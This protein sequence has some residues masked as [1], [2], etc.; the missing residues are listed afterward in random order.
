MKAA[1]RGLGAL[2]ALVVLVLLA[3]LAASV[4]RL[5]VGAQAGMAQEVQ[6]ARAQAAVRAGLDWGLYKLL[7]PG[8]GWSGCGVAVPPISQTLDLRSETGFRVTVSCTG[9]AYKEGE[10]SPG[11]AATTT[12]YQLRAVACNGQ[13][14]NCPDNAAALGAQY[15]ERQREVTVSN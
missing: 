10:A 11:T 3:L 7:K 1:S 12:V 13:V 2:A 4:V 8:G 5:S 6:G 15:V 14:A 9:T